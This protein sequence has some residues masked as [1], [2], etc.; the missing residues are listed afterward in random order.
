MLK[1]PTTALGSGTTSGVGHGN[2]T[3][4]EPSI[5]DTSDLRLD[6]HHHTAPYSNATEHGSGTTS[7][8]GYG[9]KKA[10]DA[11]E[12]DTSGTRFGSHQHSKPYTGAT[13]YGS[14]ST[15]GAGYGNK[16]TNA[17]SGGPPDSTT[18]KLME[19]VGG[20]LHKEGMVEKGAVKREQAKESAAAN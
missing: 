3:A 1:S 14:G 2:K 10:P 12:V 9:N 5:D 6:K 7:G 13:Q 20:M 15:G 11:G 18:G 4:P 8:V 19:K 17:H 16:H